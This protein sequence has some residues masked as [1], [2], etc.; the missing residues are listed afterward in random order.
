MD[1]I[2]KNNKGRGQLW[3]RRI[4]LIL[5]DIIC[6][7][8]AGL[9]A[10]L[11]R[12]DFHFSQIDTPY[13]DRFIQYLPVHIVL[14][15]ILFWLFH[16]YNSLWEF[17]SINEMVRIIIACAVAEIEHF[18]G[19]TILYHSNAGYVMPRSYWFLEVVT[20]IVLVG[21]IRF[22]YRVLRRMSRNYKVDRKNRILLVGAGEAGNAIL[23]EIK[24]SQ[25]LDGK[26]VCVVDD[27]RSKNNRYM[28]GVKIVGTRE[29][30][31]WVVDKYAITD[32]FIA[33]PSL[34]R[35]ELKAIVD[36]C[37][38]TSCRIKALPGMYQII[39]DEVS[40]RKLRN[41]S[42]EDLLGR[43]E[44]E[45]E[46]DRIAEYV[47]DKVVM[48]TG[49]GGSIGSELCRQIADFKPSKLVIVEIYENNAYDIQQE[50]K[51]THPE[52][53]LVTLIASV[54]N[55][56]RM[57][58]IFSTYKPEIV[59][60]AAAHKHVPLM[61]DSPSE[62][63]K[64]N[65]YGTLKL[66]KM[67]D[68]YDV[69]RMVLISTD[70]AVNPTNVM[71]ASKRM[72]EMIV[73]AYNARSKTEFV[74]VRFGNVLGSNGSVI[75]LFE[76]Q[77]AAGG[78]VTVTHKDIVR[79][80]MTIPEAVMLVLMAGSMAKGGEIFVLDMGE[81]VKID[82]MARNLIRLSGYVPDR[83]IE[84]VYTGLRPGEKLYEELLMD[85][86]GTQSTE[87]ELIHIGHPID[88]DEEAFLKELED[89]YDVI[90]R[91]NA[92]IRLFV[93]KMVNTYNPT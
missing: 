72:C 40:V 93:K 64:N 39:N 88:F 29:D 13:L 46:N 31:P 10:L 68:A 22:L 6:I 2:Q 54:R 69:K 53:N 27:D 71:G 75:P 58:Y 49:G 24:S 1:S 74:A 34:P 73:Q 26:V 78:P 44:I 92:D 84:I 80:F 23:R 52:L 77:I 60:H 19:M 41:I 17:A 59:F 7:S 38:D 79:Y 62:A 4:F 47:T 48:V 21:G 35:K 61:E 36:L 43:D 16:M 57:D 51:V 87:N 90:I 18:L 42:L 9:A 56:N 15:I 20:L 67:C 76:K 55:T 37:S 5:L 91:E 66:S 45:V 70:K 32:I 33:I 81:P 3:I 12:F 28:Q 63:I 83:D 82:D 65:V 89:S 86:E 8:V 30:I 14:T 85:E 11:L 25:Y 50:L